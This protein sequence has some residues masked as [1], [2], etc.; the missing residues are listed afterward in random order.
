MGM[1]FVEYVVHIG[2]TENAH[3]A[4]VEKRERKRTLR[5]TGCRGKY[6]IKNF[7]R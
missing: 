4:V 3:S 6:N 7:D 5:R 2:D 1:M